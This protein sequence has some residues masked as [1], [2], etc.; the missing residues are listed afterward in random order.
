M[1]PAH[2]AKH[3]QRLL[4]NKWQVAAFGSAL[5]AA[6]SLVLKWCW[7]GEGPPQVLLLV[8]DASVVLALLCSILAYYFQQRIFVGDHPPK[9]GEWR[10]GDIHFQHEKRPEAGEGQG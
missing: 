2:V 10:D 3:V 6:A 7:P 5:V 8:H 4:T 1:I 9:P